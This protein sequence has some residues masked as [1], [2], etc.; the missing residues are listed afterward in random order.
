MYYS[1]AA[2]NI[3]SAL[4]WKIIYVYSGVLDSY[5]NISIFSRNERAWSLRAIERIERLENMETL[6]H[7][8]FQPFNGICWQ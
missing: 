7:Y 2:N 3:Y 5:L 6:T 1:T 8:L 4:F